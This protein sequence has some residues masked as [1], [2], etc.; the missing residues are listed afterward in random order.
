MN[1]SSVSLPR[2][3][4]RLFVLVAAIVTALA[5]SV[6]LAAGAWAHVTVSSPDA[7]PGGY[8]K[9]VFR[10]P[11]ESDTATTIALRIQN[12]REAAMPL[13]RPQRVAGWKATLTPAEL[14]EPME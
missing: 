7:T 8:G 13:L 6:V 4:D 9:L 1:R 3:L 10:V 14:D 12:P 5:A 2:P 11:N